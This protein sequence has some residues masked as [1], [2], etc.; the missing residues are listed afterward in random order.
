[1]GMGVF[2]Q[3]E[4]RIPGAHDIGKAIS[5]PRIAGGKITDMRIFL[6]SVVLS[7]HLRQYSCDTPIYVY[8]YIYTDSAMGKRA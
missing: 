1:M 8:I 7:R 5:G 3:K 4:Q 6:I 2:Q